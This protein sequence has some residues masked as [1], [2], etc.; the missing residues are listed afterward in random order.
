MHKNLKNIVPGIHQH[1][2]VGADLP[3]LNR[4][5]P[6]ATRR[7][8]PVM[9]DQH[10]RRAQLF[11]EGKHQLHDGLASREVQ[12]A[13]GLVGQQHGGLHHKSPC[14]GHTLLLPARQHFGIVSQTLAQADALEHLGGLSTC[15]FDAGQLQRQHDVF[16]RR[17]VGHELETLEHKTHF[18]CPQRGAF[19]LTDGKQVL[20]SQVHR[21]LRGSIQPGDD[22]KQGTFARTRRTDDGRCFTRGKRKVNVAQNAQGASGIGN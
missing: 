13:G 20:A 8:G 17:K 9:G 3:R 1:L 5:A 22:R 12:A 16:K 15:T 6:L 7:D 14:Q 2:N 19:V 4:D 11:I 21:S 10:Q 18:L